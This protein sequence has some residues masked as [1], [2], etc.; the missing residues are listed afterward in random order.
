MIDFVRA[1]ISDL[2]T[3]YVGNFGLGEDITLTEKKYEFKDEVVKEVFFN[4]LF[5]GFDNDVFYQ[6]RK[7]EV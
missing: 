2:A 4:Y 1:K 7:K 6:F 5:Q 3:H